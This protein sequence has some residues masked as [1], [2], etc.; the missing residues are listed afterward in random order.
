MKDEVLADYQ[1]K[2][3]NELFI[4]A[5]TGDRTDCRKEVE[6]IMRKQIFNELIEAC[7]CAW[8]C[9]CRAVELAHKVCG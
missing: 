4:C 9:N 2:I 3:A 5:H 6:K 1:Q 8:E 7:Q